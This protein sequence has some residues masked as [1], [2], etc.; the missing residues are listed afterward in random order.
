[1]IGRERLEVVGEPP[2]GVDLLAAVGEVRVL[3]VLLRAAA[4]EVL[5]RA[6]DAARSE[7]VLLEALEVGHTQLGD[8]VGVLTERAR[9]P[10]PPRLGREVERRVQRGADAD[11]DVLLPGDVGEAAHRR[12]RRAAR[13]G[14]AAR[15]TARRRLAEK[16]T[17]AFSMNAC[18]GSVEIVTGMPW[19][20]CSASACSA[21]CHRAAIRGVLERVDVEVAEVLVEHH[22]AGR[23][24][25]DRARLPRGPSR[26]A[27]ASM[28]VWNIRPTFSSRESRPSRSSTRSSTGRR[29]SSK[30][31]IR[32]LPLRSR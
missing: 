28:T 22:H 12:P 18:R 8:E 31:S 16:E 5:A 2:A 1:M 17:P 24:L 14:R 19:G 23:R 6:G 30:G 29:G 3:A 10:R 4:G 27:P 11:R 13:P 20:V 9:L 15:A 21:L 25:A 7:L 32:P 26:P